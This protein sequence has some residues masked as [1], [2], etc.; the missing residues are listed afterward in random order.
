MI[1]DENYASAEEITDILTV[2]KF[3][4][5]G[6]TNSIS[7]ETKVSDCNGENLG[8][9]NVGPYGEYVFFFGGTNE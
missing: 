1:E 6:L 2:V 7:F 3:F 8:T 4:N 5:Q 9:V